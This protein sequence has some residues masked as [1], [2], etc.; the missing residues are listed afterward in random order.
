MVWSNIVFGIIVGLVG[1][2]MLLMLIPLI[3]GLK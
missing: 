1:I 2:I 3:K